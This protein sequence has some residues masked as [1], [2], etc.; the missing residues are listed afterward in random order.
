MLNL[1]KT[2]KMVILHQAKINNMSWT[3]Y[4]LNLGEGGCSILNVLVH[5][6]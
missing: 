6:P 1:K 5:K 2:V 3:Y 4:I